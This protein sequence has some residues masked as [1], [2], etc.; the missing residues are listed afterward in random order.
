[1][2]GWCTNSCTTWDVWNPSFFNGISYQPQLVSLPDFWLPS[3]VY[4]GVLHPNTSFKRRQGC[5]TPTSV[6]QRLE[7]RLYGV[8]PN[9]TNRF[10]QEMSSDSQPKKSIKFV[11]VTTIYGIL[12]WSPGV[13]YRVT[14]IWYPFNTD[15]AGH[16]HSKFYIILPICIPTKNQP[17]MKR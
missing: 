7:L 13:T 4:Q 9:Q 10:L 5:M 1:M 11:G 6:L 8:S 3:T 2:Y 16:S 17:F 14:H 12:F 15:A